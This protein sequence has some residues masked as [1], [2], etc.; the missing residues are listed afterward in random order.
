MPWS[1]DA[2]IPVAFRADTLCAAD[3][4][5]LLEG[6][7]PA[8]GGVVVARFTPGLGRHGPGCACCVARGAVGEALGRL[9]LARARGE[10][11]FF[12][13]VAVVCGEAGQAEVLAALATDP[14][15]SARFR[16]A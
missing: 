12:R 3:A 1:L 11:A 2:R 6:D 14:V 5:L 9:F 8:P 4:A 7:C 15:V 13:S 16:L 10:V